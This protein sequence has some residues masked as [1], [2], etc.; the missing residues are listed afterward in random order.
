MYD[1]IYILAFPRSP[2]ARTF[3]FPLFLISTAPFIN[4]TNFA[5]TIFEV[6]PGEDVLL[7]RR[8]HTHKS[9]PRVERGW[10]AWVFVTSYILSLSLSLTLTLTLSLSRL[11]PTFLPVS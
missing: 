4:P 6:S 10:K 2:F 1:L 3:L 8:P 11:V 5:S 9:K 7:H